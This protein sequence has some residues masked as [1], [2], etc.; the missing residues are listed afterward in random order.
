MAVGKM[1]KS[2]VLKHF[3]KLDQLFRELG[4]AQAY[5]FGASCA[6]RQW[7]VY[8]RASIG[9]QWA[10]VDALRIALD[11]AWTWLLEGGEP[12]LDYVNQF[13]AALTEQMEED[14]DGGAWEVLLSM[15]SLFDA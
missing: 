10:Q 13:E 1:V 4:P 8:V 14:M 5:A 7:P 2:P 6:E 15:L 9:K 3:D 11:A 12:P